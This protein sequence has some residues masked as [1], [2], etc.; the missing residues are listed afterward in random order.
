MLFSYAIIL[1]NRFLQKSSSPIIVI[2]FLIFHYYYISPTLQI[3]QTDE[4]FISGES[5]GT[6]WKTLAQKWE[7]AGIKVN[8]VNFYFDQSE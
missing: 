1:V 2:I 7:N 4:R 3:E 5:E 8:A 6:S